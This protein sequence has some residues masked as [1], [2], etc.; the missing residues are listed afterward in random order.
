MHVGE[1]A[2]DTRANCVDNRLGVTNA[3]RL[4]QD[5]VTGCASVKCGARDIQGRSG[6]FENTAADTS[7]TFEL[8]ICGVDNNIGFQL[9]D[10]LLYKDNLADG[11]LL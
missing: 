9:R 6:G 3:K 4:G 2:N 5:R 10:V 1:R 8:G 7:A 11:S